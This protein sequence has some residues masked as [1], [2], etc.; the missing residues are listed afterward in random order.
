MKSKTFFLFENKKRTET[1]N[2]VLAAK[3]DRKEL[4][5]RSI[6]TSTGSGEVKARL[7]VKKVKAVRSLEHL[8][9]GRFPTGKIYF[10]FFAL[11]G[12]C[13][14]HFRRFWKLC[15]EKMVFFF[16][17][18]LK[19][20]FWEVNWPYKMEISWMFRKLF[21]SLILIPFVNILKLSF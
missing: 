16:K 9:R 5:R 18:H 3:V 20:E 21:S 4:N 10:A 13:C 14:L 1:Q 8:R 12:R 7:N 2:V 6:V 11:I 17:Q 19:L 15:V